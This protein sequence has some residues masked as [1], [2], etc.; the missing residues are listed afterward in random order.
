MGTPTDQNR[1]IRKYE[2]GITITFWYADSFPEVFIELIENVG[3]DSITSTLLDFL[4]I[5]NNK[6]IY[7]NAPENDLPSLI[8][9]GFERCINISPYAVL[10]SNDE[11]PI[12]KNQI[13]FEENN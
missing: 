3:L 7:Y 4:K 13:H 11:I 1:Y 12:V 2:N 8:D 10:A 9:I 5:L 6:K